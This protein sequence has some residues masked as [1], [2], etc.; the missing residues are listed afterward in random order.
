MS[1]LGIKMLLKRWYSHLWHAMGYSPHKEYTR[2][3]LKCC[4]NN[5]RFHQS[6]CT[7]CN[8]KNKKYND[9]Y[10]NEQW[11]KQYDFANFIKSFEKKLS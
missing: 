9:L 4:E 11:Q 6:K 2:S 5:I 7:V 3:Y 10:S 1:F 8:L